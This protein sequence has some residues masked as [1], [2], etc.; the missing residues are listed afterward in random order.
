MVNGL[1]ERLSTLH[2]KDFPYQLHIIGRNIHFLNALSLKSS[3]VS[4][5]LVTAYHFFMPVPCTLRVSG[6]I[7][8]HHRVARSVQYRPNL[9]LA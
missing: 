8:V 9:A 2:T 4:E 7:S 1:K 5:T 3:N 6:A